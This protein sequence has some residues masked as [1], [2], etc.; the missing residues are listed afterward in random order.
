[1]ARFPVV[2]VQGGS[3]IRRPLLV[4]AVVAVAAALYLA[5]DVLVPTA[6]AVVLALV[7]TPV[8]NTFERV[9]LP[10][11][12]AAAAAA[13]LLAIGMA[14]LL[15]IAVP[16]LA[17]WLDQGPVLTSTLERK[18][19]GLRQSLAVVEQVS[20][21]V[22][23]ATAAAGPAAS[24]AAPPE[25]VVVRD[26]SLLAQLAGTAPTVLLQI[27]YASVLSFV[28]L[29]HR[30]TH[31]RQILRIP[32]R[33]ATR[34]RLARILRDINGRVGHY[35]F[36]LVVI[37]SGVAAIAT[38]A[39]SLLGFPNAIV[40][41]VLMGLASFVPFIGPTV[42]IGVVALVALLSFEDWARMLAA[43]LALLVLHL[44]ESQLVTPLFVSRRCAL[45]TVAVFVAIAVLGWM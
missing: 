34:V 26:S 39:L 16:A 44:G 20:R 38:V 23:Q 3:A 13:V 21:Q 5:R 2:H 22:E 19:Q 35:L 8:A 15:A 29:A 25:K 14:A 27:G 41:G 33:Y 37:Y 28:L 9:R 4:L 40:W 10:P 18:L 24:G 36:A 43:P 17:S 32:A 30:N 45:N 31:R 1:M 7:L 6:G 42:M 11:T 12:A